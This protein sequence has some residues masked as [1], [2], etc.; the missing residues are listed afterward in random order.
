LRF[1]DVDRPELGG[2]LELLLDG[3]ESIGFNKPDNMTIDRKGNLLIQEDPG[4]N[5]H[6]SR[7]VAYRIDDGALGV[8]AQFDPA[9]FSRDAAIAN[10]PEF[11]TLDEESSGIV[12]THQQF[13]SGTFLFDA[14]VHTT[15]NLPPGTGPGTVQEF[16]ENGQLLLLRVKHWRDVYGSGA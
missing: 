9:R 16:V 14:Q 1:A 11:L 4:N 3:S 12:T 15:K 10:P 2:T 6:L 5:V 8:V 13:G 7:I